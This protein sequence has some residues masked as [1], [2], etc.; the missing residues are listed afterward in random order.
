MTDSVTLVIDGREVSVPKGTLV[1]DAAKRLDNSIPV[2]CYHPKMAPVGMCRMCLVEI[3]LPARDRATGELARDEKGQPKINFGK[4][5]QT[6]CTVEAAE[7]MVVRTTTQAVKEAR[8]DILE[9]LLTSHPL[10]CPICDKGGECPLQNL[11]MRYGPGVSRFDF[12]DKMRLAKQYPLGELILLDRERCI[13]CARCIRFQDEIVADPVIAFHERGRHLEIVSL[14]E[15][16]FDSYWS[17]N[18]T[19]ICPV[20]A[21]TTTDFRFQARPWEMTPVASLCNHCPV[22]CN[23]TLGTRA[24]ARSG[25]RSVIKRVMPRQNEYVNEIWICDKGRFVNQHAD[26]AQRLT[27]P[28]VREGDRL[29]ETSWDEALDLVAGKLQLAGSAAAG[30]AGD[31]LSNEDLY[32]FQKLFRQGLGSANIDL[33]APRLGGGDVVAAVGLAAGSNLKDLGPGDAILVVAADLHEQAPVYWLRVKQ[34]AERGAALVTLNLR[35]TRLDAYARHSI[36]YAP[37]AALATAQGLLNAAKIERGR[38]ADDALQAAAD[39]LIKAENLVAFYAAE[40]L[41]RAESETLA[42]LLGN[43]LL[44][45]QGEEGRPHAGRRNNGLVAVWPRGNTQGAW[46]MG[47]RPE[48]GPGYA[49]LAEPGADA[50]G[51]CAGVK[52]GAVKALFLAASDPVGDGLLAGRG[53]L[54]FLAVQELFMSRSAELA[55]VVLPAQS[56]AEREGTFTNG[57]RRVQRFYPAIN[58]MGDSRPDWIV[59]AQLGERVGLGRPAA[60]AGLVF[61]EIAGQVPQYAGLDYRRLAWSEAQWPEVGGD[62][63][64]Y[65]GTAYRNKAGLGLQ[66]PAAAEGGALEPF[67]LPD[68]GREEPNGLALV[69]I[70]ALYQPGR[71]IAVS[72]LLAGRV[73]RPTLYL[74]PADAAELALADGAE[75]G[76]LAA[77]GGQSVQAAVRPEAPAGVALLRG[78]PAV[79]ARGPLALNGRGRAGEGA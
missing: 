30:L 57:E 69:P 3:G 1:V 78:V 55:D 62:D 31:R 77:A 19:D 61:K 36:R 79:P 63:M 45:K 15:P 56:W 40:G 10:D 67:E 27:R 6:A 22:G 51:I 18:T 59:L 25:G 13:Q 12:D 9:F 34:A 44:V 32:L 60:S 26:S 43:L 52:S 21:L 29:V 7:G 50:A 41:E 47:V 54:D 70:P 53:E 20:G 72:E 4:G 46:D 35:P 75:L 8:D 39:D 28:L 73:A 23:T 2:F 11:T 14:S 65:G 33:T 66:W 17:G 64:Y 48:A 42:R 16:G 24:E 76:L 49:P 58:A 38:E 68:I 71:L 37:G 74:N 5:L